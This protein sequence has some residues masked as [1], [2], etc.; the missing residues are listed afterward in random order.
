MVFVKLKQQLAYTFFYVYFFSMLN[1]I[2]NSFFS[3]LLKYLMAVRSVIVCATYSAFMTFLFLQSFTPLRYLTIHYPSDKIQKLL[4][5]FPDFVLN[6][7]YLF[8]F[9][10]MLLLSLPFLFLDEKWFIRFAALVTAVCIKM[11]IAYHTKDFVLLCNSVI[12]VTKTVDRFF[13]Q[14]MVEFYR[15]IFGFK[16]S[17]ED[18]Y[19]FIKDC[20]SSG[21]LLIAISTN[22]KSYDSMFISIVSYLSTRLTP[23]IDPEK[24]FYFIII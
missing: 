14:A 15:P 19:P 22:A 24:A 17:F 23:D 9:G 5:Y 8:L 18:L 6:P 3:K 1:F 20:R 16:D 4:L 21:D 12:E 10:I 13:L 2:R 11:L 7:E